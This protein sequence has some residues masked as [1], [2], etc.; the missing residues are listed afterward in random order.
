MDP[1]G[2]LDGALTKKEKKLNTFQAKESD[3]KTG[4]GEKGTGFYAS[5]TGSLMIDGKLCNKDEDV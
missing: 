2:K 1:M 4:K 5:S 3:T